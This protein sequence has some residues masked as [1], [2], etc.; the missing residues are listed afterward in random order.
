MDILYLVIS[1]KYYENF[2]L[3]QS[4]LLLFVCLLIVWICFSSDINIC[5]DGTAGKFCVKV[6]GKSQNVKSALPKVKKIIESL[7]HDLVEI[8]LE[9]EFSARQGNISDLISYS[10][11]IRRA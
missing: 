9:G 8:R 4:L 5:C 6:T 11:I 3:L 10:V 7:S 2:S 1:C